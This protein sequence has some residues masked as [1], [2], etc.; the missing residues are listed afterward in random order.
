MPAKRVLNW[1]AILLPVLMGLAGGFLSALLGIGGGVIMVPM[2]I[3]FLACNQKEAQGLSLGYMVITALVGF[4]LYRHI[5]GVEIDLAVVGLLTVGG[6]LGALLGT[7]VVRHIP[8]FWLRKMFAC[9][10]LVVALRMMIGRPQP[11]PAPEG[12]QAVAVASVSTGTELPAADVDHATLG[13]TLASIGGPVLMGVAGGFLSSLL[14]IGGGVI[15]VPMLTFFLLSNQKEAQG[16]S[17]GYM[18]ITALVGF[19]RYHRMKEVETDFRVVALLTVGGI[20]GALLGTQIV[21]LIPNFWLKKIFA[22]LILVVAGRMLMERRK[23]PAPAPT[24]T[25]ST[26]SCVTP[27]GGSCPATSRKSF[28]TSRSDSSTTSR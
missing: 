4:L 7:Q 15:M 2:L 26:L 6:V 5:E 23:R 22:V 20:L 19:L 17:L 18:V 8:N 16:L 13:P 10:M 25:D 1:Y 3:L 12:A 9:L 24:G 21:Q 14:G 11:A 28:P 27:N